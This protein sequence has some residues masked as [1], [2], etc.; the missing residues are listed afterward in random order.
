MIAESEARI[1]DGARAIL[2]PDRWICVEPKVLLKS[3][4]SHRYAITIVYD[5][6]SPR[7]GPRTMTPRVVAKVHDV[8][9]GL[10]RMAINVESNGTGGEAR[11]P[12][13]MLARRGGHVALERGTRASRG[14]VAKFFIH[15][16]K[17][18]GPDRN[19]R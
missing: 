2:G 12:V 18:G 16:S 17:D 5:H 10:W 14:L 8:S 1:I 15:H 3:G 4:G 13:G 19:D 6:G 11:S 9:S 7:P